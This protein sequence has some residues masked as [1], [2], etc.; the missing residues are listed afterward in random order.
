MN[1]VSSRSSGELAR[2]IQRHSQD[3]L[4]RRQVLSVA[5]Q[6]GPHLDRHVLGQWIELDDPAAKLRIPHRRSLVA[7]R[8]PRARAKVWAMLRVLP[9]ASNPTGPCPHTAPRC[10]AASSTTG[11]EVLV[12]PSQRSRHPARDS[13]PT[14]NRRRPRSS[15]TSGKVE[16]VHR[17]REQVRVQ[18]R[19][20]SARSRQSASM[21]ADRSHP[22]TSRPARRYGTSNRPVPQARSSAGCPSSSMNF[23]K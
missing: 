18:D 22:S 19:L 2:E 23:W 10:R 14:R 5:P 7:G 20:A 4:L 13:R 8:R 21:S 9:R 11:L 1:P 15:C 16:L 6:I 17:L 3:V 12:D